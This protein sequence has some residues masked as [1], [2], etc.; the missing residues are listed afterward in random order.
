MLT[1]GLITG[2]LEDLIRHGLH[3][4]RETLQQDKELTINNT[5]IGIVGAGGAHEIDI[6]PEGNFRLLEGEIIQVYLQSMIPKETADAPAHAPAAAAADA[7]TGAAAGDE[8][9]QMAE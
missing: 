1:A 4:L 7:G 2:T 3:A 5:S 9:V 6:G 8:D